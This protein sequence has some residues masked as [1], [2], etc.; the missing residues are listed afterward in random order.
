MLEKA[1][2]QQ[3]AHFLYRMFGWKS[4]GSFKMVL[5]TTPLDLAKKVLQQIRKNPKLT[6]RTQPK[7]YSLCSDKQSDSEL[8]GNGLYNK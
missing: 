4:D 6:I 3:A 8:L 7:S 1:A 5:F 2:E